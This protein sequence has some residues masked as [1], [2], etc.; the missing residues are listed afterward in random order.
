MEAY[1]CTVQLLILHIIPQS[2]D[3][4]M[5]AVI[6]SFLMIITHKYHVTSQIFDTLGKCASLHLFIGLLLLKL[7]IPLDCPNT[8]PKQLQC[9]ASII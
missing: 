4:F 8:G 9:V 2:G 3:I 5:T 1:R 7:F 6:D